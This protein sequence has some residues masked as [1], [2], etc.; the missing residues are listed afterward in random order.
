MFYRSRADYRPL[1][2]SY[3]TFTVHTQEIG[4]SGVGM[5]SYTFSYNRA[6][7]NQLSTTFPNIIKSNILQDVICNDLGIT[8]LPVT[9]SASSVSGTNMFTIT[10]EG[11]DP[12]LT[13]DILL[14]VIKNYPIVADYVIGNTDLE[15]LSEPAVATAPS[16]Y[17]DYKSEII[18]GAGAGIVLGLLW[19]VMYV[20]LRR[21]V[22]EKSDVTE[23]LGQKC[24]GI[25]PRVNFKKYGKNVNHDVIITNTLVGDS[26]RE[27]IRGLR[28]SVLKSVPQNGKVIML[29]STAPSE[30]KTT[31]A[32]NL[33]LSAASMKKNVLII[34]ADLRSPNVRKT[35]GAKPVEFDPS[36]KQLVKISKF[37]LSGDLSISVLNFNTTHYKI[38]HIAKHDT[39]KSIIDVLRKNYDY[40]IIDTSPIGLTS[41]AAV[42][43]GVSDCAYL[44]IK[45]DDV[46]ISR[47]RS[48]I[49]TMLSSDVKLA[50]CILNAAEGGIGGYG[51]GG[52]GY[53]YG[54]RYG[55]GYGYGYKSGYGYGSDKK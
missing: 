7:A 42:F 11:A 54:H 12:Q 27:G 6:T 8:Y 45:Q 46:R 17:P 28:N 37:N 41:E 33:A 30:G 10:A 14:S 38:W 4:I 44:V 5:T 53:G 35:F 48:A 13:Y 21:T 22:A 26:Y 52:Y 24:I 32:V 29:S 31:T 20:M 40:I 2:S 23:K 9:L 36:D 34:D 25:L 18:K 15:I 39:L 1:Y 51:Y 50:G 49:D 16:N 47:I 43:G 55:Y 19:A 3:V